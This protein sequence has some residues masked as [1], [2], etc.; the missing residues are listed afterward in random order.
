VGEVCRLQVCQVG[1]DAGL[2]SLEGIQFP[3]VPGLAGQDAVADALCRVMHL[4]MV[5]VQAPRGDDVELIEALAVALH[6][7]SKRQRWCASSASTSRPGGVRSTA[8]RRM[9]RVHDMC[10]CAASSSSSTKR[11]VS[12]LK[13]SAHTRR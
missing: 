1:D 13:A 6:P 3:G 12:W 2:C 4:P 7:G 11:S 5:L 10:H 8:Q 9:R